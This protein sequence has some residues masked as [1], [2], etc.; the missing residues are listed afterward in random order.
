MV[1]DSIISLVAMITAS[2]IGTEALAGT[3]LASYLFII[4]NAVASVFMVGLLVITSQAYG[5]NDLRLIERAFGETLMTSVISSLAVVT[6]SPLW[7]PIYTSLLSGGQESVNEVAVTYLSLRVF[8]IPALM[9]NS[10]IATLFR[11]VEKPWPPRT[12]LSVSACLALY[13]CHPSR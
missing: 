7:L 9:L 1:P 6:T 5:G 10:V 12:L 2:K 3:G 4:I 13:S 8:S 11:A